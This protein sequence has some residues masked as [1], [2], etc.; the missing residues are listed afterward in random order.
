[1]WGK[2]KREW[3]YG[4]ASGREPTCQYR[5]ARRQPVQSLGR[6][7]PLE[8][9]VATHSSLLAWRIPQTE[10]PGGLQSRGSQRLR[11]GLVTIQERRLHL[12]KGAGGRD[13]TEGRGHR[14]F[15]RGGWQWSPT[16]IFACKTWG[17]LLEWA[18]SWEKGRFLIPE[19]TS[20]RSSNREAK[21]QSKC[22][23]WPTDDEADLGLQG[24]L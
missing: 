9:G 18:W 20:C 24:K 5:R 3:T 15:D 8:E 19:V 1:M 17:E 12:E 11:R 13:G 6:E 4:G 23:V 14:G 22:E 2:S 21:R 7:G 10:E 16:P